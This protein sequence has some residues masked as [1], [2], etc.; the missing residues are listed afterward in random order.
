MEV[1][2]KF[3]QATSAKGQN[4]LPSSVFEGDNHASVMQLQPSAIRPKLPAEMMER[5]VWVCSHSGGCPGP[6]ADVR[7]DDGLRKVGSEAPPADPSNEKLA[8][9]RL[10]DSDLFTFA[11]SRVRVLHRQPLHVV[12]AQAR[13]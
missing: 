2:S 1:G 9:S 11:R 4:P 6:R 3:A 13:L 10:L 12:V 7:I 5:K 8:C